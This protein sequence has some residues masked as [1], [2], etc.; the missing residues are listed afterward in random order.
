MHTRHRL[1]PASPKESERRRQLIIEFWSG[2]YD[3]G[4]AGAASWEALG[5]L[6]DKVTAALGGRP[7]DISLAGSLTAEAASLLTGPWAS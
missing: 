2:L 7:A 6:R 5:R 1:S 4:D 3:E